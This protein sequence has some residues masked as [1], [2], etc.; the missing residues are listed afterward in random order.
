MDFVAYGKTPP[1]L[2]KTREVSASPAPTFFFLKMRSEKFSA[3]RSLEDILPSI[4][5]SES[6]MLLFPE[7][8][9]PMT[10][11]RPGENSSMDF[12]PNDLKPCKCRPVM[13]VF[14]L[15]NPPLSS[16]FTFSCL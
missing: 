14:V 5:H 8:F 2:S 16:H 3:R 12:L 1:E 11:F 6:R 10:V 15:A 7:P 4:K 13:N 9:G